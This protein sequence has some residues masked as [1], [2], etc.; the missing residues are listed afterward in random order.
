M[1]YFIVYFKIDKICFFRLTST[2]IFLKL[3]RIF[4]QEFWLF[5]IIIC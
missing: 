2:H 1:P 5:K 3:I 4:D